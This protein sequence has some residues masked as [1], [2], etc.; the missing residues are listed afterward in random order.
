[1]INIKNNNIYL[2]RGDTAYLQVDY[3]GYEVKEGDI[4]KFSVKNFFGGENFSNI[5]ISKV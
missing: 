2:T 5:F 1:M 3:D 4:V